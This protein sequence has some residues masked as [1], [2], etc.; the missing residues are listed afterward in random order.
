VYIL[1][2]GQLEI[3]TRQQQIE[4][5]YPVTMI[6]ESAVMQDNPRHDTT[7]LAKVDSICLVID[8]ESFSTKIQ[9]F[10]HLKKQK[11]FGFT[12][13][14]ALTRDWHIEKIKHFNS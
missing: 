8:K 13:N 1:V 7:C 4:D 5:I 6:G 10:E 12:K 2:S 11:R 9:F 14:L 3:D